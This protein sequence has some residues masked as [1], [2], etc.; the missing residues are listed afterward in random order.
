MPAKRSFTI[1]SLPPGNHV[2]GVRSTDVYGTVKLVEKPISVYKPLTIAITSPKEGQRI[3]PDAE[4][5]GNL[6]IKSGTQ[7]LSPGVWQ[8]SHHQ[9]QLPDRKPWK[10]DTRKACHHSQCP[11]PGWN[12]CF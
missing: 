5:L 3:S 10:T 6:E 9:Q 1:P 8:S 4:V 11:G 12:H 2:L 7:N